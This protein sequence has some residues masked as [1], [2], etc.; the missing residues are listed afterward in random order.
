MRA[1]NDRLPEPSLSKNFSASERDIWGRGTSSD[2]NCS[3]VILP[4]D[5]NAARKASVGREPAPRSAVPSRDWGMN[6]PFARLENISDRERSDMQ[7]GIC[8]ET[9]SPE[10]SNMLMSNF[11]YQNVKD[12]ENEEYSDPCE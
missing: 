10:C 4:S 8:G 9:V 6:F 5:G 2:S 3:S 12:R 1:E 7:P 11:A